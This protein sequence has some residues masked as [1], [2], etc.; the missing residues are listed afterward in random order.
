V[1]LCQ[2]APNTVV[3]IGVAQQAFTS[4]FHVA[5][6]TSCHASA[7]GVA[8]FNNG[9]KGVSAIKWLKYK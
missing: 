9:A 8:M 7:Y 1:Q 6:S 4:D 5:K 2:T 3:P